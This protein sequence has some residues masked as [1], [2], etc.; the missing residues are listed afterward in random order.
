MEGKMQMSKY[1]FPI[2]ECPGCGNT[3]FTV[4]QKIS[5]YGKY[6]VNMETE[7]V[8]CSA[9]YDGLQYENTGKYAV[10]TK[11][12]K[13]LFKIDNNLNVVE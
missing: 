8:D 5:G 1:N 13:K 2:R 10:C 3:V 4:R 12:G 6:Y 9:L 11:C 7:E